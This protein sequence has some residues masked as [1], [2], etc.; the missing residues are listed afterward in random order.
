MRVS[1]SIPN[2]WSGRLITALVA[3]AVLAGFVLFLVAALIALAVLVA[4]ALVRKLMPSR[5]GPGK[6]EGR[7]ISG[8]GVVVEDADGSQG[9]VPRIPPKG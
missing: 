5:K 2:T 7:I 6:E 3:V 1:F 9:A 4:V 8:E